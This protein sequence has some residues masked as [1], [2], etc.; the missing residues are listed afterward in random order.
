VL[1]HELKGKAMVRG[2]NLNIKKIS[3]SIKEEIK[4]D[5][6]RERKKEREER[7]LCSRG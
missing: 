4:K 7:S 1:R 3:D 6:R 5:R 2:K